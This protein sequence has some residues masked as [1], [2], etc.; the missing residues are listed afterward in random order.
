MH[1]NAVHQLVF[2][3][4][5]LIV[6]LW[7]TPITDLLIMNGTIMKLKIAQKPLFQPVR[8]IAAN[9]EF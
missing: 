3:G 9:R 6:K 1:G 4:E 7:G 2:V 8:L 5:V